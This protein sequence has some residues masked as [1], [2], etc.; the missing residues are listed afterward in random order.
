MQTESDYTTVSD[1]KNSKWV[2][3]CLKMHKG[4]G[5]ERKMEQTVIKK[6]NIVLK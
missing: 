4:L 6:K 2:T 3:V 5:E 1:G